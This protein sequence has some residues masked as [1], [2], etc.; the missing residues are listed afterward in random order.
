MVS[1]SNDLGTSVG[2]ELLDIADKLPV[3]LGKTPRVE[4]LKVTKHCGMNYNYELVL[5]TFPNMA[6]ASF[7]PLL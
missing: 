4:C 6:Y 5:V 1:L 2:Q 7:P 3:V